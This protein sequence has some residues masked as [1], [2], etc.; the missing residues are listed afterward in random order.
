VLKIIPLLLLLCTFTTAATAQSGAISGTVLDSSTGNTVPGARISFRAALRTFV[1]HSDSE[2]RFVIGDVPDGT[3]YTLNASKDGMKSARVKAT[4][5]G[6]GS[7]SVTVS[8]TSRYLTLTSHN[9][10]K[11]VLAGTE[12]PI[13]WESGGIT[14]L[15]IEFSINSGKDW[16]L[17]AE[18]VDADSGRY[19]WNVDDIPSPNYRIRLTDENDPSFSDESDADFGNSSAWVSEDTFIV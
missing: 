10:G 17:I 14:T 4:V 12:E 13:L 3:G 1:A 6:G 19:I 9:S 18:H 16:L 11:A 15:R 5:T 7:T 2:G 8:L